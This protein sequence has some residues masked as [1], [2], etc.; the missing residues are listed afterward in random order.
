MSVFSGTEGG[1]MPMG[2]FQNWVKNFQ[3]ENPGHIHSYFYGCDLFHE[4][5]QEPGCVGIRVYY[6]QDD[7]G[8][9]KMVLIGVNKDGKD[10]MHRNSKKSL[11]NFFKRLFSKLGIFFGSPIKEP[12]II[13]P[14]SISSNSAGADRGNPCPPTC[15]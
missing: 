15:G 14:D 6:A 4:M 9:P 1:F 11:N 13:V 7:E 12:K 8:D 2:E 5:L 10:I 3:D